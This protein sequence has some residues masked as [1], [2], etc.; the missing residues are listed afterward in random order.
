MEVITPIVSVIVPVYNT[1]KYLE[2]CLESILNQTL[3]DIEIICIEDKST[4]NSLQ[5]LKNYSKKDDRIIILEN[6]SN[7]GLS[8]NRNKGLDYAKG[9]YVSFIDSDDKLDVDAYEKLYNFIE[10]NHQDFVIFN[11][12]RF[13]DDGKKWNSELHNISISDNPITSTNILK[14]RE[15]VFDSTAWNKFINKDF[16][17]NSKIKFVEGRLY[18]DMLFSM[19]LFCAADSVGVL[20]NIYYYWRVRTDNKNKSI[21]QKYNNIENIKDRLFIINEINKLLN[22]EEYS[23]LID[24]YYNKLLKID[25]R[26]IINQLSLKNPEILNLVEKYVKPKI[27]KMDKSLFDD[28]NDNLKLKY[29]ILINGKI[30]NIN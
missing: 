29:Y 1:D 12:M 4:D 6:E 2:E 13:D 11:A 3:K 21:T 18:E 17:L 15:F 9:K 25:Y 27:L 24:S 5:I 14:N 7:R 20:P 19:E 10:E 28:L 26:H 16:L 23:S 30:E 8:F 22:N